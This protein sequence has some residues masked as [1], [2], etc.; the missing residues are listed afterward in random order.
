MGSRFIRLASVVI[1]II[2]VVLAIVGNAG[3]HAVARVPGTAH[4]FGKLCGAYTVTGAVSRQ[5][6]VREF[7]G[8][9]VSTV[10]G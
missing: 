10:S 5:V 4:P 9:L 3:K 7:L 1:I 8:V 6:G 2:V